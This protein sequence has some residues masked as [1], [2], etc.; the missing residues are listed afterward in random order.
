MSVLPCPAVVLLSGGMDSSACAVWLSR[1]GPRKMLALLVGYGQPHRERE[2]AA[3]ATLA[4]E[5]GI[6]P[7]RLEVADALPKPTHMATTAG[8]ENGQHAA[9]VHARNSLLLSIA[10]AHACSKWPD[11]PIIDLWFGA[12]A[13]DAAGFPDCRRPFFDAKQRELSLGTGRDV[14]ILTPLIKLD[15]RAL[16]ERASR[17]TQMLGAVRNSWSCYLGGLVP[18]GECTPCTL[19]ADAFSAAGIDDHPRAIRSFGGDPHREAR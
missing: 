13:N 11:A 7:L 10:T 5:L 15:K 16:V 19:R 8:I 9:V 18:C 1:T 17:D 12:C 2:L 4:N 14:R 6:E 3:A